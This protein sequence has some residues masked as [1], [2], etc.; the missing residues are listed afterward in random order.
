MMLS[1]VLPE[2]IVLIINRR[3][4]HFIAMYITKVADII[5]RYRQRNAY[6]ISN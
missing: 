4:R 1:A 2:W 5:N 3:R 6:S